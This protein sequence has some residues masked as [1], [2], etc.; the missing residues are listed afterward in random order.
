M[1]NRRNRYPVLAAG[2]CAALL[3][4]A[5]GNSGEDSEAAPAVTDTV[6]DTV[7]EVAGD[8]V[9]GTQPDPDNPGEPG[10]PEDPDDPGDPGEITAPGELVETYYSREGEVVGVAGMTGDIAPEIIR[11][12]PSHDSEQV[13][14]VWRTGSVELAGREWNNTTLPDEGYWVEVR[15]DGVQGWMPGTHL[16]YFGAVTDVTGEWSHIPTSDDPVWSL[17]T[18]GYAITEGDMDR[19]AIVTKPEDTGDGAYRLDITGVPDDAQAGER[20]KVTF[21]EVDGQYTISS[22]EKTLLCAR[23]LSDGMCL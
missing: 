7:T 10:I 17:G 21:D 23:G 3:L 5:C 11:A 8:P 19:W 16:F 1:R 2:A 6:T 9:D 14:Q 22:A 15:Q 18:M 13:G 20:L 12:Q 4:G